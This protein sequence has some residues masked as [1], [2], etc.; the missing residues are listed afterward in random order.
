MCKLADYKTAK[1]ALVII[2]TFSVSMMCAACWEV[3]EY[4]SSRFLGQTAQGVPQETTDGKFI[5]DITDSMLDIIA[6][7]GGAALF[8]LHYALHKIT[9]R[10]L[11]IG[12]VIKDFCS[13]PSRKDG[14]AK[15]KEDAPDAEPK[16]DAPDENTAQN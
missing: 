15:P 16:E 7:L 10:S 4:L 8:L 13:G 9:K 5:V 2:V 12:A 1:P 11:L 6:N 14:G 3:M